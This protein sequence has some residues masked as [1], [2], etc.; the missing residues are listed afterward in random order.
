MSDTPP[1]SPPQEKRMAA[2]QPVQ[3]EE[4]DHDEGQPD[5]ERLKDAAIRRVEKGKGKA[6]EDETKQP[7]P[8]KPKQRRV[9]VKLFSPLPLTSSPSTRLG[10]RPDHPR[11]IEARP[12][13]RPCARI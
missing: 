4:M 8:V 12:R 11:T 6:A 13:L 10:L 3:T 2:A 9:R 7:S 5:L 1:T